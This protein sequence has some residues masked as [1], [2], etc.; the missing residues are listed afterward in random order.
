LAATFVQ[1]VEGMSLVTVLALVA[2]GAAFGGFARKGLRVADRALDRRVARWLA[3]E[4]AR[5]GAYVHLPRGPLAAPRRTPAPSA[6]ARPTHV[7][8]QYATAR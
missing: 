6:S 3:Q 4:D 5:D 1:E 2:L 7:V 8:G